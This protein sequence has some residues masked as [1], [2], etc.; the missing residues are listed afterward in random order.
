MLE[1]TF[2]SISFKCSSVVVFVQP[3]SP[4]SA[5]LYDYANKTLYLN[6]VIK[7]NIYLMAFPG[8]LIDALNT[9]RYAVY[10]MIYYY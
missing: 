5:F 10:D 8:L 2:D 6:L 4:D 3:Y 7:S 9:T 1:E